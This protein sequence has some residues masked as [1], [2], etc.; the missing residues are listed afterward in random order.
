MSAGGSRLGCSKKGQDGAIRLPFGSA[1][2]THDTVER[3]LS[4]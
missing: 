1:I 2:R 4:A 3:C